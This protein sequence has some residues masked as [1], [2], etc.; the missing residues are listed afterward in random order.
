MRKLEDSY[1]SD[2]NINLTSNIHTFKTV[3]DFF[4]ECY[5]AYKALTNQ[6]DDLVFTHREFTELR[7]YMSRAR[8]N[9]SYLLNALKNYEK[10]FIQ[11][12]EVYEK[13]IEGQEKIKGNIQTKS[14][15]VKKNRMGKIIHI[16]LCFVLLINNNLFFYRLS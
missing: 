11:D 8:M 4:Y 7:Q 12:E 14:D 13:Y 5:K 15:N 6:L 2:E 1:I 9:L 10:N 16:V 3:T